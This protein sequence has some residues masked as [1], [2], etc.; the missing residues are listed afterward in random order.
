MNVSPLSS[1]YP[2]V[3]SPVPSIVNPVGSGDDGGSGSGV[4]G[5]RAGPVLL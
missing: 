5:S 2:V 4:G 3:D 1:S